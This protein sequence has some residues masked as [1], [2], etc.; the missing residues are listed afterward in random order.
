[1]E[2]MVLVSAILWEKPA[3]SAEDAVVISASFGFKI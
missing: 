2:Q 1:M 3:F